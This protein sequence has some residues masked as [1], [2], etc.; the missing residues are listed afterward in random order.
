MKTIEN[1]LT[2]D[3]L[4]DEEV[5]EDIAE[6]H[7]LAVAECNKSKNIVKLMA[8]VGVFAGMLNSPDAD[9]C[10]KAAKTLLFL[11][12]HNFPKVRKLAAEKLYT[13]LLTMESYEAVIPGGEDAYDEVNELIS[14]TDWSAEVKVLTAET[15]VKMYGYFGHEIKL[16]EP[17]AQEP[18][19]ELKS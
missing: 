4:A 7:R 16:K 12:Y 9:L 17:A 1:L 5:Q 6:I 3:Y 2:A 18:A 19:T 8:G 11:L 15:K 10:K 14:E 13:G